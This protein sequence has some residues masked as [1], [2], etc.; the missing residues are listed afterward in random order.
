[1]LGE[2]DFF[3]PTRGEANKMVSPEPGLS[4]AYRKLPTTLSALLVTVI[5]AALLLNK[6]A[7]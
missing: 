3:G 7:A 2:I 6:S 5:L 4:I 1:M